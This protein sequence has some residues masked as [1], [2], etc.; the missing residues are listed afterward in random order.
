MI[1]PTGYEIHNID[2][3]LNTAN[4][5]QCVAIMLAIEYAMNN[6]ADFEAA[7]GTKWAE[8]I[9]RHNNPASNAAEVQP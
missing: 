8:F 1:K 5:V 4:N 2:T 7:Q 9:D 6:R 3:F